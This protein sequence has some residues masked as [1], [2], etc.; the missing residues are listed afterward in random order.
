MEFRYLEQL[1]IFG[2]QA[3][4]KGK[5]FYVRQWIDNDDSETVADNRKPYY[6]RT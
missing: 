1:A 5:I 4:R 6:P 3:I 2:G